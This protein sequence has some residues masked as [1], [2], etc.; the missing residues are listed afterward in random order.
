MEI[1]EVSKK[2]LS[3]CAEVFSRAFSKAPWN[4]SWNTESALERLIHFYNSKGFCGIV[5]EESDVSGFILGNI[6]PYLSGPI[7]YLREMCVKSERQ[8]SGIGNSLLVHLEKTLQ[9]KGVNNIY[10]ITEH[11]IPAAQFYMKRGYKVDENIALLS[12]SISS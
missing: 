3:K 6:E 10:L 9:L 7:F 11:D 5:A 4:E 12:K 2:D 1:R 8:N